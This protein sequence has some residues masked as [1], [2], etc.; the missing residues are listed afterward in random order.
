M[1][2][3]IWVSI[4]IGFGAIL[5]GCALT[6]WHCTNG[7]Q[8]SSYYASGDGRCTYFCADPEEKYCASTPLMAEQKQRSALLAE[9]QDTPEFLAFLE[10][11]KIEKR[12]LFE[13]ACLDLGF[14]AETDAMAMCMLMQS[15]NARDDSISQQRAFEEAHRGQLERQAAERESF[16]RS[17]ERLQDSV[18]PAPTVTCTTIGNTTTCR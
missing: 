7:G 10:E 13:K 18:K 5:Q 8:W 1:K 11:R 3:W 12:A 14:R 6:S 9:V 16:R 2:V 15:Q 4:F 17:V